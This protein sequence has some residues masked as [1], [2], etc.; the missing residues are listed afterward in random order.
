M[1]TIPQVAHA[2]NVLLN[3]TA[4]AA[5]RRTNFVQRRSKLTGARFVQSLVFGW[6]KNPRA[7][8]EE[9]TQ[10][11]AA[12]G[13]GITP[14]GLDQRFGPK[15]AATLEQVLQAAV[16]RVIAGQPAAIPLLQ[17]FSSVVLLD[18]SIVTLPDALA[19]VW[20]GTGSRTGQGKAALKI[21]VRL[22]LCTGALAGPFL[23][24]GRCHD[25][26][27][28][29]QKDPLPPGSLRLADLGY[30][31]LET[32]GDL[33]RQGVFYLSRLQAQTLV[34]DQSGQV[35]DLPRVLRACNP[36]PVDLAVFMGNKHRLPVRLLAAPVEPSVA[37]ERRRRLKLDARRRCQSVSKAR[38]ALADWTILV[39][40][41]PPDLL[42]LEEA[43]VLARARWQIE[44]LFKLW[45]QHGQ[46]DSWR[47]QKPWR[48]LCE[49]YAKLLAVLVQHW[50]MVVSC[51]ACPERSLVKGAYTIRGYAL[52]LASAMGGFI[53]LAAV[54]ELVG[55]TISAGCRM[56][57]R[58]RK[59][60]TYQLLL[61]DGGGA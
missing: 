7:S 8:L 56:N 9:L 34:F 30:F 59:P 6:L 18:S 19:H 1:S 54:I 15:A 49:L 42:S 10:T 20:S 3:S 14:Q 27:S 11:T 60:N 24:D 2:L 47:T 17:R 22:D 53:R 4:D 44:L 13:V 58:R 37:K 45:K 43:L 48:M 32:L 38:L 29:L 25:R 57:P 16:T 39:T 36:E 41:T 23:Q 26:T 46:I 35:L 28:P 5:A 33:T 40:N 12:L 51:W 55:R 50:L 31:S 21:Q 52:M 61:G